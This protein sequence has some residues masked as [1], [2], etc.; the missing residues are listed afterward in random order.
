[1]LE[2]VWDTGGV[3]RVGF[4][5]D[6]EDIVR[7]ISRDVQIVGARLVML[8]VQRRQL[9]LGHVL[10]ALKGEAMQ[11]SSGLRQAGEVRDRGVMSSHVRQA[12]SARIRGDDA[13]C[14]R[15]PY[16]AQHCVRLCL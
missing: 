14:P 15:R 4:E 9:Q 6:A 10:G 5:T 13:R 12:E 3:W 1:M 2:D 16:S 11:T 7:I 8:E